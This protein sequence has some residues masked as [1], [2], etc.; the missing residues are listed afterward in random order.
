MCGSTSTP[1]HIMGLYNEVIG[2]NRG[3]NPDRPSVD[4]APAVSATDDLESSTPQETSVDVFLDELEG[5]SMVSCWRGR[6]SSI[7]L[8]HTLYVSLR[9]GSFA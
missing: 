2:M 9:V 8:T 6:P 3:L 7:Q 5:F 4:T 1:E